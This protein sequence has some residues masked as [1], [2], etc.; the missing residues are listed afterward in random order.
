MSN[1]Q[2]Q[3]LFHDC[4]IWKNDI[5]NIRS[6]MNETIKTYAASRDVKPAV[7]SKAFRLF[8]SQQKGEPDIELINDIIIELEK[9]E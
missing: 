2:L 8:E 1:A 9:G 3:D 6:N 4:K 7:I 5:K